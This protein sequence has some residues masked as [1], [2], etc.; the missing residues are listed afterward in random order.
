MFIVIVSS[1]RSLKIVGKW[2]D[3]TNV[4][5][6]TLYW[7]KG[8]NDSSGKITMSQFQVPLTFNKYDSYPLIWILFLH[9]ILYV[10]YLLYKW[11][12]KFIFK[13]IDN[14]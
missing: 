10:F 5:Y 8:D 11:G 13:L 9:S 12:V 3:S 6:I 14:T 7:S 2:N 4:L 1:V